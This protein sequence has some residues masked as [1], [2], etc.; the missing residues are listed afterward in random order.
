MPDTVELGETTPDLLKLLPSRLVDEGWSACTRAVFAPTLR[1][2][3]QAVRIAT[4]DL[5]L[6][7]HQVGRVEPVLA[8]LTSEPIHR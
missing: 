2:S 5:R 8:Q 4:D 1:P 3:V 7:T 6:D